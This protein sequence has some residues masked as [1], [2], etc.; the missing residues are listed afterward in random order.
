MKIAVVT[1]TRNEAHR[2]GQFCRAYT[3][4]DHVLV[5][6]GGSEDDTVAIASLFPNVLLRPF[7][8]RVQLRR[9]YWRNNDSQHVNHVIACANELKPDWIILDDCDCRPNR[10]LKRNAR[11][12]L[13]E[14]KADFVFAVR[15]FVW[16]KGQHFPWMA[17]PAA[18]HQM[19]E[20]S[21]WAWRGSVDF[22]TVDVPP[23]YNFRIGDRAI[24]D[25][26]V[27][28]TVLDLLPP[29]ALLHFSW[30]DPQRVEKKLQVY[31]ESGFIPGQLH[32]LDYGGPLE[33]L[34]EWAVE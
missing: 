21:L 29:L 1:R 7:H 22:W 34:P 3:W 26:H 19:W 11:T 32:P 33:P 14:A 27:D 12:I 17:K 10:L 9:G 5:S 6:D 16:E 20:A 2:I 28:S 25:L 30:D 18:G 23:A 4:A 8:E 31:R 24:A 15:L 13:E